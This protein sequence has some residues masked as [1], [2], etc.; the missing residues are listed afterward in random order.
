MGCDTDVFV[1]G[2]GPAGLAAA[3]AAR[4]RGFRVTVADGAK[5]PIA[6]ACGEGLLPDALAALRQLGVELSEKDGRAL[7]GIQFEDDRSSVIAR[8]PDQHG[9]GVRREVLHQRMIECAR[10][11]GVLLLWD[12][13]VTGV[14]EARVVAGGKSIRARWIIGADGSGSRVRRWIGLES[15]GARRS[16]FAFRVHY[17]LE[18]WSDFTE[19]HW[20]DE[21]QAY[22]TPVGPEEICIV[23]ISKR[24]D[25]RFS[26]S[27]LSFPK[28]VERLEGAARASAE[29]GALT[30]MA[31]LKRVYRGNV[32]LIG[33]ASGSVDAITAEGLSLSFRQATALADALEAGDLH[34]YQQAHQRLSRRPWQVGNLLL[35]LA[36]QTGLRQ[37]TMRS[38]TAAPQLFERMLAYQMGETRP[39]E[40]ATAGA[41]FGWR[42]LAA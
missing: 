21:A 19:I 15:F 33:D 17:R 12:T 3:I 22:V 2:G 10:E 39:L 14:Q 29:R 7:R 18:P 16:R 9:L 11:C 26:Q 32:G 35:L 28:L 31:K 8:F 36:G 25:L 37:R 41:L 24:Q 1:V 34:H 42:F 23:L 30:S 6:K 13:P 5:P 20:A 4:R 38:L 27:L 40:L